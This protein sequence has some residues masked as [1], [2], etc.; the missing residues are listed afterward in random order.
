MMCIVCFFFMAGCMAIDVWL[1]CHVL[2]G[3]VYSLSGPQNIP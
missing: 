1:V 2:G 3:R